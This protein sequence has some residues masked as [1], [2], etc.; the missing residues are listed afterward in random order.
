MNIECV[1]F[2][3]NGLVRSGNEDCIL[4]DGWIRNQ[5]MVDPIRFSVNTNPS[6]APLFAL[7]DGLG[8]HSSGDVAS[9]FVLSR[10][11]TA[12]ANST[13]I[14]EAS[15]SK[16]LQDIHRSL[17]DISGANSSYRGMGATVVGLVADPSGALFL[18][19]VGD[20][21]IYRREDRFLQLL[22]K[23]DRLE[24]SAYGETGL[25]S[26]A[27]SSLLQCLGGVNEFVEIVPHVSRFEMPEVRETYLLCSDGVSDL[28]TQ[29]QMEE[30]ISESLETTVQTL[31]DRVRNAG[32]KDN[33]S[34]MI[35]EISPAS[36]PA[37]PTSIQPTENGL[38]EGQP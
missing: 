37:A 5:P 35:V 22:T 10:L 29:D 15:L 3:H 7:A 4:C 18:F 25:D 23:D 20:S 19:N 12:I 30:S 9:Q 28:L 11:C 17:F 1:A 21:R 34:I 6:S 26:H 33:V 38:P 27:N 24:A 13:A 2:T 32:A 14:S 36:T 31:F 16:L 8:G